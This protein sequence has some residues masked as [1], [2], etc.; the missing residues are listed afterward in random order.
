R[1]GALLRCRG[2]PSRRF[3]CFGGRRN[4]R[5]ILRRVGRADRGG[6]RARCSPTNRDRCGILYLWKGGT[7]VSGEV[8]RLVGSYLALSDLRQAVIAAALA[9]RQGRTGRRPHPGKLGW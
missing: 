3:P 6:S 8:W 2:P 1:S 4:A 9:L 5:G 7:F